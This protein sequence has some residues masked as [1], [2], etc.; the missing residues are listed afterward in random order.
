MSADAGHLF[1][2]KTRETNASVRYEMEIA[3]NTRAKNPS[4]GYLA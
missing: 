2:E 3:P 4:A 1:E